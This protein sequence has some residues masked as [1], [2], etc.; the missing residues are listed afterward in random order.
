MCIINNK[1]KKKKKERERERERKRERKQ[2][3]IIIENI[4]AFINSFLSIII[5]KSFFYHVTF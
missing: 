1:K 3:Q 4:T 5:K 2:R